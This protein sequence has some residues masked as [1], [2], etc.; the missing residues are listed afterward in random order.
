MRPFDSLSHPLPHLSFR[1]YSRTRI[2]FIFYLIQHAVNIENSTD[3][4]IIVVLGSATALSNAVQNIQPAYRH[5][6]RWNAN[7]ATSNSSNDSFS[8]NFYSSLFFEYFLIY[9]F[10]RC[11]WAMLNGLKTKLIFISILKTQTF[12]L[13]YAACEDEIIIFSSLLESKYL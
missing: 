4:E 10:H 5:S 12:T 6:H 9:G 2:T 1:F 11:F 13:I 3:D 8:S 7:M